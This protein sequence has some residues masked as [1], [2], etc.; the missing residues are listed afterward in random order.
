MP[1]YAIFST[2]ISFI[3][4]GWKRTNTIII[5][6]HIFFNLTTEQTTRQPIKPSMLNAIG[7]TAELLHRQNIKL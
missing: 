4:R 2:E 6:K 7:T 3:M 1:S 5:E